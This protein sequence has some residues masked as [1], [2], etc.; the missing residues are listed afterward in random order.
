M[1]PTSQPAPAQPAGPS[2]L[3]MATSAN[4]FKG[5]ENAGSAIEDRSSSKMENFM[6][7]VQNG[8]ADFFVTGPITPRPPDV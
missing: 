3:E 2:L 6:E 5:V 8:N 4:P 7:E 1:Q